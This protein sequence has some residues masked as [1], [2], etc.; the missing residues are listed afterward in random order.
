VVTKDQVATAD[1][2]PAADIIVGYG[3][4]TSIAAAYQRIPS[5]FFDSFMLQM[6]RVECGLDLPE[7]VET[8][9]THLVRSGG[10]DRVAE[11]ILSILTDEEKRANT[12]KQQELYYP[13]PEREGQAL[14][15]IVEVLKSFL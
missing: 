5:I 2:I 6:Q 10:A 1:I 12:R 3:G 9:V 8:G 11:A 7:P 14:E 4:S 13:V 15:C